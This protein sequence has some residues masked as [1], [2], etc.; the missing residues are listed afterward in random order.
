[1]DVFHAINAGGRQHLAMV[2]SLDG[3]SPAGACL[4]DKRGSRASMHSH[5]VQWPLVRFEM[6]S[7]NAEWQ[8][9]LECHRFLHVLEPNGSYNIYYPSKTRVPEEVFDVWA[10]WAGFPEFIHVDK[11]GAFEG[12]FAERTQAM[13]VDMDAIPAEAHWQAGSIEAYNRAFRYAAEKLVD[14]KQLSGD[15]E[16]KILA[17]SVSASMNEKIRTCGCSPSEWLFGRHPRNP[18]DLLSVDGKIE[19]CRALTS[20]PSSADDN[21]SA[22]FFYYKAG[23]LIL[24]LGTHVDDLLGAGAPGL[25]DEVLQRVKDA[26]D[27][28]AWAD[29]RE[30]ESLEYGGK[31]IRKEQVQNLVELNRILK[32]AKA[33]QDWCLRFVPVDLGIVTYTDA[34]W[35]NGPDLKS[36]AGTSPSSLLDWRSHRIQRQ[37]RSTLAAET[38]AMDCGFDS[39]VF[40][41][42]LLAEALIQ[43][44]V[45]TQS[46]RLP[47]QLLPV[48]PVTDCRSLYDLVTKDGPV[49][50]TQEKR[51]TIDVEA[52]KQSAAEFDPAQESL[53]ET[54]KWVDTH[55]RLADHL[56]KVKPAHLLRTELSKNHIALQAVEKQ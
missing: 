49:H 47:E 44:Y 37:C 26:F 12:F 14:E 53:H 1:M 38:M 51:L 3:Q 8:R 13:G 24:L 48:H 52:I 46:G 15:L 2:P 17:A 34:S 39:G 19:P 9:A 36:Q 40:V 33:S 4:L 27:F 11:D 32:E 22:L 45:P 54:F 16:M 20:K 43:S 7:W 55:R 18:W 25:A 41:R 21:R 29:S 28:G 10:S 42:E 5:T 35:A 31:Q 23:K 6:S 56:T 30:G 50:S